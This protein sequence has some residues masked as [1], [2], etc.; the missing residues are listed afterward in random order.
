MSGL[1][2]FHTNLCGI[3]QTTRG[4]LAALLSIAANYIAGYETSI[5]LVLL[6][7]VLDLLWG[8]AAAVK[9]GRYTTSELARESISKVSVYATAIAFMIALDRLT[10]DTDISV[11]E[12]VVAGIIILVE[13]WS[14]MAN[15]LIVYPNMPLLVLFRKMLT[16]EIAN[17]LGVSERDVEKTLNTTKSRKKK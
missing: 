3:M 16:G 13:M 1:Q 8:I 9:Q 11:T 4:W 7:V 17:K 10:P 2:H 5:C 15:A 6:S 14:F 12:A